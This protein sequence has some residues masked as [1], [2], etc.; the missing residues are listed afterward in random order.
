MQEAGLA[1]LKDAGLS[2]L[3]VDHQDHS[4]AQR[5]QLRAIARNLDLVVT[6]SSDFHGAG[7]VGHDLG[8]NTTGVDQLER[9]LDLAAA[10]ARATGRRTPEVVLP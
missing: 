8:C 4:P 3:E 1:A 2:G 5:D 6:G 9:L 10:A 7:K